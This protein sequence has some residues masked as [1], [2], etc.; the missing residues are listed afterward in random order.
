MLENDITAF[1]SD[2]NFTVQR[3]QYGRMQTV[4]LKPGGSTIPVTNENKHEYIKLLVEEKLTIST[5]EQTASVLAGFRE[6]VPKDLVSPLFNE[7]ELEL[8][9]SGL[10]EVDIDDLKAN[11]EYRGYDAG[12]DQIRWFW[13]AV[14]EFTEEERA[15]L[16]QFVHGSSK[17]PLEGFSALMGMHGPSKF[18]IC[19]TYRSNGLPT[20]HTCF[21]S[22][23]EVLTDQGFLN[24]TEF[25]RD[26]SGVWRYRT[27][28]AGRPVRVAVYHPES[29]SIDYQAPL[30]VIINPAEPR[31]MLEIAQPDER[32][33]WEGGK[34]L[35]KKEE[36]KKKTNGVAMVVTPD[37]DLYTRPGTHGH[38][39]R[40]QAYQLLRSPQT[41]F[42]FQSRVENGL[43][44][45]SSTTPR[46]LSFV[47]PHLVGTL[48]ELY[49]FA[50][51]NSEAALS[52]PDKDRAL[53][54]LKAAPAAAFVIDSLSRLIPR[55]SWA[56][57]Q[58]TIQAAS[59]Y[60][61]TRASAARDQP[62]VKRRRTGHQDEEGEDWAAISG[63]Q[64]S[65]ANDMNS[66]ESLELADQQLVVC[67]TD[68]E[69]AC[70]LS[71]ALSPVM[72][73][74]VWRLGRSHVR[75]VLRGLCRAEGG[76]GAEKAVRT[77]TP[78]FR[79]EVVRLCIHAGYTAN[80]SES[81][82]LHWAETSECDQPVVMPET[83]VR[84]VRYSG[85]TW[86]VTVQDPHLI[87]VRRV[88]RGEDGTATMV[89]RPVVVGN[90]F[91]QIDLPEYRSYEA[92]KRN[93]RL[94]VKEGCEGFGFG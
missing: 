34:T 22:S 3:D 82:V 1:G 27:R 65:L 71:S 36:K 84:K 43:S 8:L 83:G 53:F 7:H 88:V 57:S 85:H 56:A 5:K 13:Q 74:W 62:S 18:T 77:D 75:D 29:K 30:D 93:L 52:L 47:P 31:T 92:L 25:A 45:S 41:E 9:I 66:D 17:V 70:L 79:D 94:A 10:P 24:Y 44:P 19:R 67:V 73:R 16:I 60:A 32:A 90:C 15:L 20:S 21:S 50:L 38:W 72:P 87:I 81:R 40:C 39:D 4:E 42:Q 28:A 26:S 80:E 35:D 55:S 89:S 23:H 58:R 14:S 6:M 49:G 12:S 11:T 78:R 76:G 59:L 86:C 68:C 64:A 51:S 46:Q 33:R 61:S 48:L 69:L 37:H 54:S 63:R 91:N 2:L